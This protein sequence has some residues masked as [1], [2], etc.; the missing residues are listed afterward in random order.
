MH[1][2]EV[3]KSLLRTEKA[4]LIGPQG[5]YIFWIDRRANKIEIK[6]AI[7]KIYKVNVISVNT[8]NMHGKKKRK[9]HQEGKT[10]DLKKAI[11]RLKSGQKIEVA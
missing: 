8:L 9:R 11:F 1:H 4:S 5:Q 6:K 10:P 2:H 3:I 7:E